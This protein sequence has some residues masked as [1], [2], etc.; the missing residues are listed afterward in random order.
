MT[1]WQLKVRSSFTMLQMIQSIS[2]KWIFSINKEYKTTSKYSWPCF[3]TKWDYNAATYFYRTSYIPHASNALRG[4]RTWLFR[5]SVWNSAYFTF[6]LSP[7]ESS[8][9]S[10]VIC[11][12]SVT[13]MIKI[14]NIVWLLSTGPTGLPWVNSVF[15]VLYC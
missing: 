11:S 9:G 10:A 2:Y 7:P 5:E 8:S 6:S 1:S 13:K 15:V 14:T 12:M 3:F 4:F